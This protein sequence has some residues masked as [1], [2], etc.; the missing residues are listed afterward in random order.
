MSCLLLDGNKAAGDDILF[1][2]SKEVVDKWFE[3]GRYGRI[4]TIGDG[5][6]FFHSICKSL[7]LN[8]Y[9]SC[10]SEKRKKISGALRQHL[11]ETFNEDDFNEIEKT[12]VGRNKL[13][14]QSI[15]TKMAEPKT[16]AE[17]IMIKWTSKV[18]KA[19]IIFLNLGDNENNMFC[20]VHDIQTLKDIKTCK[21]PTKLTVIVAWIGHEHFELIV[22]IDEIDDTEVS[23]R[24]AFNPEHTRDLDTITNIMRSYKNKCSL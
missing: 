4:G 13:S 7:N 11:S 14:F 15:K 20:G 9:M 8:D 19:N 23:I 21:E 16:W 1:E 12:L 18:L 5:S 22:R 17:E 3:N 2:L 10:S 6:C 24:R